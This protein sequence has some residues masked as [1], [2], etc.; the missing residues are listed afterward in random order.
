MTNV[1]DI[2][3][4]KPESISK[5]F[6]QHIFDGDN[7][8]D[9]YMQHDGNLYE[10]YVAISNYYKPNSVLEIG[11]RFGYSLMAMLFGYDIKEIEGIDNEAMVHN[12]NDVALWNVNNLFNVK[13]KLYHINS[14]HIPILHKF[15]DIIH[16]DGEHEQINCLHDLELSKSHTKVVIVDDYESHIA[17]KN[18]CD[19]FIQ[20]NKGTIKNSFVLPKINGLL[21]IEYV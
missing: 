18:A 4:L 19:I 1:E 13:I 21:V 9:V 20:N 6:P 7:T 11:V 10:Y 15:Y 12:S 14:F 2:I 17:V 8:R 3:K 5:I 16:I